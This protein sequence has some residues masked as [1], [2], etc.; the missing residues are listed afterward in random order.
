M[1]HEGSVS[2][3]ALIRVSSLL[4]ILR[5]ADRRGFGRRLFGKH[6]LHQA[7]LA[8]PYREIPLHRYL[9]VLED[10]AA[11][12]GDTAFCASVGTKFR[13]IDLGPVGLLFGASSTLRRGLE[14]LAHSLVSWQDGTAIRIHAEG[15]LLVWTYHIDDPGYRPR[16]QDSEYSLAATVALA[17][18]AF[19]GAGKPVEAHVEHSEPSDTA[20]LTGIL[21]VRPQ[22]GQP[23]NRLFFDLTAAERVQR[24]ED[25]G[26]MTILTRHLADLHP[27]RDTPADLVAHIRQLVGLHLGQRPVTLDLI[28]AELNL[29]TRTLQRRL[30]E[31][32]TSL[33]RI[34]QDLRVETGRGLLREGR[35]SHADIARML[36]YGDATAFW[37]AFKQ[38]TGKAPSHERKD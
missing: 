3:S 29:S 17:R 36:G 37:R 8:D 27:P 25:E 6:R 10:A 16:R 23:A 9:A 1:S 20:A 18:D 12:A 33:R 21:G 38:K 2:Q 19:G 7:D 15:D 35:A 13:P 32:A 24:H 22:Y 11:M 5:E 4:P 14:R 31:Q 28:A 34:V 26:L 30:A